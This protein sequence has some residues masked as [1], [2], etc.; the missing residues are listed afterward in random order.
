[1]IDGSRALR[2]AIDAVFGSSNPIQR[3]RNHK[4]ENVVSH[5]PEELKGQ[6]KSVMKAAYRLDSDEGMA[7]LKQQ[8]RWLETEY[9]SAAA[10]LLEGLEETFT[11]NRLGLPPK[12]RRCLG[13]TNIVESPTSGVRLRTRRVT[14]WKNGQ[15]VLRWAAAAYLETEKSF[16]RIIGYEE[17]WMLKAALEQ[18]QPI[19]HKE[20][21][22]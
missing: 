4:V 7:K 9:P 17:L 2:K 19:T 8:A 3:C 6:V 15:M 13:T 1:M 16:R 12:L 5:L 14:N 22:A 20:M 21:V 11:I 10:S 18:H